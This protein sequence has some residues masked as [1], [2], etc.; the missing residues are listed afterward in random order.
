M[1]FQSFAP[2]TEYETAEYPPPTAKI[3]AYQV[4]DPTF[5]NQAPVVQHMNHAIHWTISFQWITQSVSL[6]PIHL[7]VTY[8]VEQ[9]GPD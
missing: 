9:L 3:A 7:I 8:Q 6:I 4:T 1:V 5:V 2:T